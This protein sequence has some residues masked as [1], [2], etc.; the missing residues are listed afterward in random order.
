MK[1]STFFFIFD[2]KFLENAA[3]NSGLNLHVDSA[4]YELQFYSDEFPVKIL[5]FCQIEFKNERP[6]KMKNIFS[7]FSFE[8]FFHIF[9]L[10]AL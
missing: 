3:K 9:F 6:K 10:K 2:F 5:V 4:Y 1:F 8:N 7:L